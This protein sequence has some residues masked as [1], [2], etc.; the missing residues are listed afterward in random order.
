M[1]GDI[2]ISNQE[3][4]IPEKKKEQNGSGRRGAGLDM[5]KL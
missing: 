4:R 3:S 1:K 5:S 2:Y